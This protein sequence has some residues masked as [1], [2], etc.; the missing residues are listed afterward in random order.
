MTSLTRCAVALAAAALFS[1]SACGGG[2]E[3]PTLNVAHPQ[4]SHIVPQEQAYSYYGTTRRD[5]SYH[6]RQD[7]KEAMVA[8]CRAQYRFD[9]SVYGNGW[10][11]RWWTPPTEVAI[12]DPE[13]GKS[14]YDEEDVIR[15]AV[16]IVN[17]SLPASKRLAISYTDETFAGTFIGSTVTYGHQQRIGSGQIHAE[18][19]PYVGAPGVGWTNGRKGFA[20]VRESEM[21][22]PEY[23]VQTMVHEIMHALG[24]M[25]HPHHTH[26]SVLSYQHH[27]TVIFDN[28]PLVD[29]AVLYEMNGWGNWSGHIETVM[30][31][32]DGVQ[33]GVHDLNFGAQLISWVDG[34]YMPLP[35]DDALS[36]TA[37]WTGTLVGKTTGIVRDVHGVAELGVDFGNHFGGWAKFHTI[38]DWDGT[39]WNRLG[40]S[41]DLYVNGYYFDSN[42]LD[43]IPDVVGAFYG[44]EAQVAA[45]TLQRPEITA[46]FG[47]QRD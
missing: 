44:H 32:A 30:G 34:G 4:D 28:V 37:S 23:A 36:G 19:W 40:W 47:A 18:I 16:A 22:D 26:T 6:G 24:L 15:R 20:F 31:T 11:V 29:V 43:G 17:R 13:K 9:C 3:G 1:L 27:S 42:D 14:T 21:A 7:Y 5:I 2:S 25:G 33:F 39:M 41:Y 45:G 12:P 8:D 46:A 35:H 10:F 38:R